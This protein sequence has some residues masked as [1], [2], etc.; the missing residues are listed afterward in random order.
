MTRIRSVGDFIVIGAALALLAI[1]A[2]L[3]ASLT[4]SYSIPSTY[5]TGVSGYAALYSMLAREG[6]AVDRFEQPLSELFARHGALVVAGDGAA[7]TLAPQPSQ[8]HA[9]DA[10]VRG[11][12]TLVLLGSAR[13]ETLNLPRL[14]D[15]QAPLARGSCAL[16]GSSRRM[17]VAGEFTSGMPL[18]CNRKAKAILQVGRRAVAEVY[19]R[20]HGSVIF[21]TTPSILDN[22]H[23]ALR[24][25]AAFGYALLSGIG[26]IAFEERI[27][28]HA[29]GNSFWE[30]LPAPMRIA[31][32][33]S[34]AAVL[35]AIVGANLPFAPPHEARAV[36][37][38]DSS[39][40]IA[41]LSR[42]LERGGAQREVVRRLCAQ[43]LSIATP[44]AAGDRDMLTLA[45]EARRLQA[46]LHPRVE[47]VIAAGR[48]FAR[49]QKEYRA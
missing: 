25:N 29:A 31:I 8:S 43:V 7:D 48:L 2:T 28:G 9:L 26:G 36:G 17:L 44:L 41:S 16:A 39:E 22:S 35:L 20:G 10:W 3:R 42:M 12:G 46:L 21:V 38:R 4:G 32:I 6:V 19:G 5:D 14:I 49:V 47:D 15:L 1:L 27:Y 13:S 37:E 45:D 24:D 40:Y 30:V 18:R 23:L 11:G 33:L 34:C